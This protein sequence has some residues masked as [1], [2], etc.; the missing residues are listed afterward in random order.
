MAQLKTMHPNASEIKMFSSNIKNAAKQLVVIIDG[1]S[2]TLSPKLNEMVR[3][4]EITIEDLGDYEVRYIDVTDETTGV[5]RTMNSLGMPSED[6]TVKLNGWK[7][8]TTATAPKQLTVEA[9]A[10][11]W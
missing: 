11:L 7:S 2:Y 4:K 3:K 10:E 1:V 8:K 9:L 5:T 6:I